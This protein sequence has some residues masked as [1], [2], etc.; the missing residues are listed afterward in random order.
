VNHIS[1]AAACRS[2]WL[3]LASAWSA[4]AAHVACAAE[5][6]PFAAPAIQSVP[7]PA[8][9]TLRV[10]VAMFLVLAAVLAAAWLAR[11]LRT[12]SGAPARGLEVL[13]QVSLGTRERAVLLRVGDRQVLV[14]VAPGSVRALHVM[15]AAVADDTNVAASTADSL[16]RP[17]F[18]SLLLRSLGK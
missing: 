11:R 12:V 17:S 5:P 8:A 7:A 2:R 18:K 15:Q 10:T 9:G 4:M 16:P 14:G 3:A 13:A 6:T 1:N